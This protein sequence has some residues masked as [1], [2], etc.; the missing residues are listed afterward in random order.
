MRASAGA[1][2]LGHAGPTIGTASPRTTPPLRRDR[3]RGRRV[4][5]RA[6][7]P[8]PPASAQ[9]AGLPTSGPSPTRAR[10]AATAGAR[11][12]RA[13][14]SAATAPREGLSAKSSEVPAQ[15]LLALDRL[16]ERLEVALAERRRAVPLDHLEE[17]RRPVLGGLGEDLEQV[18]VLVA[19]GKDAQPL[20]VGVVL[21]YLPDPLLDLFVVRLRRVEEDDTALLQRLDGA[22][23]VLALHRDVLHARPVVE[24]EVLLDLALPLALRGLVDRE[25]DLPAPVRHHLGH[26]SGVL[27]LDLVV[28][29]MNDVR[30]PEDALVEANPD[31]HPTELDIADDVVECDQADARARLTVVGSR[32]IAGE[33]CA[34]VVVTVH[35][36][37]DDVAVGAD[38]REL[39]AAELVLDPLRLPHAARAALHRLAVR[40]GGARHAQRDDLRAV[41]MTARELCHLAVGAEA[42][43]DHEPDVALLKHVRRAIADARLRACVR[44][45]RKAHGVLVV[46]RRLL[47]VPDP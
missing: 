21:G 17:D 42:A 29:E 28:A 38:R 18:P 24:L 41:T 30:H 13:S 10:E 33:V 39:D 2:A 36:R 15:G 14:C 27:G 20:Q 43:R 11:S 16:E 1:A 46:V 23:D 31:V 37:V 12:P 3:A 25:L 35:E 47:R 5:A 32:P 22:D 26:Q 9:R 8:A 4:G 45:A 19:V 6:V 7:I 34:G 44:S 40:L